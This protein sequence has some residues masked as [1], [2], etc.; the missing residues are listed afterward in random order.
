MPTKE[1]DCSKCGAR[2]A[3]PVGKKCKFAT[4]SDVS[5]AAPGS[6]GLVGSQN[7]E[8]ASL[9]TTKFDEMSRRMDNMD[10]RIQR[11]ESRALDSSP[12]QASHSSYHSTPNRSHITSQNTVRDQASVV[13]D[14]GFLKRDER[15][16]GR[17]NGRVRE[18]QNVENQA[19]K[20][21]RSQRTPN[22]NIIV[23]KQVDWPQNFVLVGPDRQTPAF[24]DLTC[25]DFVAGFLRSYQMKTDNELKKI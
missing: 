5:A 11:A 6:S 14:I 23:Q 10:Q 25:P 3:R 21:L 7:G 17:I 1:A 12:S 22:S 2:H 15:I 20:V 24:D 18:L 19:G 8:L 13:P 4:S 16:Q 9:I